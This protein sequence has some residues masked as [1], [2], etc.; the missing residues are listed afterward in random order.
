MKKFELFMGCLG[1]GTT[2]CNKA[3]M[4]NGDYKMVAHISEYGTI[5]W[6]VKP[7][8]VPGDALLRI[9]HVA[10]TSYSN[11]KAW[12]DSMSS[13]KRY[14]YLL[15]RIPGKELLYVICDMKDASIEEKNDY[16]INTIIERG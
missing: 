9:E 16:M 7:E 11:W 13:I 15:D 6:Y 14:E 2:V 3:V 1:N 10:D 12:I 8:T 5:K 4:E